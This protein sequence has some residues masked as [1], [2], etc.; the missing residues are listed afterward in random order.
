MCRRILEF[1]LHD[2]ISKLADSRFSRSRIGTSVTLFSISACLLLLS[3]CS[4]I[5]PTGSSAHSPGASALSGDQSAMGLSHQAADMLKNKDPRGEDVM[6]QA[7][8]LAETEGN[9]YAIMGINS[10]LAE[11]LFNKERYK[12]ARALYVG[13]AERAVKA[14]NSEWQCRGLFEAVRCDIKADTVTEAD[15]D[16][17][18]KGLALDSASHEAAT[19]KRSL[20]HVYATLGQFD[21]AQ[22]QINENIGKTTAPPATDLLEQSYLALCQGNYSDSFEILKKVHQIPGKDGKPRR[23]WNLYNSWLQFHDPLSK[24]WRKGTAVAR[25]LLLAKDYSKL[26]TL[27]EQLRKDSSINPKGYRKIYGFYEGVGS[28]HEQNNFEGCKQLSERI[29]QWVKA[30]PKS[31]VAM[32]ALAEAQKSLAWKAR[33]TGWARTV[34][35]EG[36]KGMNAHLSEAAS[37]LDRAKKLGPIDEHWYGTKLGVLLGQSASNDDYNRAYKEGIDQFPT[38]EELYYDKAYRLQPRWHGEPGEFEDWLRDE[39]NRIG[40]DNGDRLYARIIYQLDDSELYKNLF[41]EFTNLDWKRTKHGFELLMKD[42][43]KAL[44]LR[45]KLLKLAE[46]TEDATITSEAVFG[47]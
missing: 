8:K 3:S 2:W 34:T 33:G 38:A 25:D 36:W 4:Q 5:T 9:P 11:W 24:E 43:P 30:N 12:E 17:L 1:S 16:M 31:S 45:G 21:K 40:G 6:R 22:A 14:N 15:I 47:K 7:A 46:N 29:G 32:T 37:T 39:A 20:A 44:A 10:K 18:K 13:I 35:E 41:A 42:Y 26:D 19:A 28:A 23:Y 27:A